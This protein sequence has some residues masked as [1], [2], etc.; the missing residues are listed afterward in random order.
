[1]VC[2]PS[3]ILS[4]PGQPLRKLNHESF[5]QKK[6]Q[7]C[8]EMK[9]YLY[10]LCPQTSLETVTTWVTTETRSSQVFPLKPERITGRPTSHLSSTVC[11]QCPTRWRRI[12]PLWW[13]T[14]VT[15][16]CLY[17]RD[18][19]TPLD[20]WDGCCRSS[21][22]G[23]PL[24]HSTPSL[25]ASLNTLAVNQQDSRGTDTE[26]GF[27]MVVTFQPDIVT[28]HLKQSSYVDDTI[29]MLKSLKYIV[30]YYVETGWKKLH[31]FLIKIRI[32]LTK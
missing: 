12:C 32:Q 18:R 19:C 25:W 5:L 20:S 1:M 30:D 7:V 21:T 13:T 31:F 2:C 8:C 22:A 14:C 6:L 4:H 3:K 29:T 24:P 26:P 9:P 15:L 23:V 17:V 16:F 11:P 10:V 27:M 28:C